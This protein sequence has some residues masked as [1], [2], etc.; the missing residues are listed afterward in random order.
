MS[1]DYLAVR[2]VLAFDTFLQARIGL[3]IANAGTVALV[4]AALIAVF[5]FFGSNFN[6]ALVE[7]C[8]YQFSPWLVFVFFF[9]GV[10]ENNWSSNNIRRNSIIAIIELIATV[11][12]AVAALALFTIR[13]RSSKIDTIA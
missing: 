1:N 13:Y 8:A 7:Q 10:V 5:F 2:F 11:A 6:A 9:W 12:S 3:S 4:L